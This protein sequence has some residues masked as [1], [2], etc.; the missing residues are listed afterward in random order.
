MAD[1]ALIRIGLNTVRC[2]GGSVLI[3]TRELND[4]DLEVAAQLFDRYRQFYGRAP[5]LEA[6]RLFIQ[7]RLT[8]GDSFLIGAFDSGNCVGFTQLYPSFSSVGLKRK[9]ILN[10][11]FVADDCRGRGAARTLLKAAE[12]LG[13]KIGAATLVLATQNENSAARALYE[14]SGWVA[15]ANSVYYNRVL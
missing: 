11:M 13:K 15:E 2:H 5:D 10:D 8:N 7:E 12:S 3:E 6:A 4:C 14:S 1:P 9:L